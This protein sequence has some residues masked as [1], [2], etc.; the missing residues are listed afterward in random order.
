[1]K[2]TTETPKKTTKR[3][4]RKK[5]QYLKYAM[6]KRIMQCVA[7]LIALIG[8]GII[9]LSYTHDVL[10]SSWQLAGGGTIL[11]IGLVELYEASKEYRFRN[12]RFRKKYKHLFKRDPK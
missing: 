8:S 1:M 9:A 5:I 11:F 3:E 12:S 6:T 4:E 10:E 2:K 7:I